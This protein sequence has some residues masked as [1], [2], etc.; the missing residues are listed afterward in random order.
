MISTFEAIGSI[1]NG[2]VVNN[3]VLAKSFATLTPQKI[4]DIAATNGLSEATLTLTLKTAGLTK[5]QRGEVYQQ[6]NAIKAKQA[7]ATAA[8]SQA[9]ATSGTTV[10]VKSL[11][12]AL[13]GL[14]TTVKSFAAAN[15]L[16]TALIAVGAAFGI[17][18]IAADKFGV[19]AKGAAEKFEKAKNSYV[20]TANE[21][22]SVNS[23]LETTRSRI[24]ELNKLAETGRLTPDQEAELDD[25]N[26]TN[27]ALERKLK[28]LED[29]AVYQQREAADAAAKSYQSTR[30]ESKTKT[31]FDDTSGVSYAVQMNGAEYIQDLVKASRD[32]TEQKEVLEARKGELAALLANGGLSPSQSLEAESELA[33]INN[34][35]AYIDST[36][37]EYQSELANVA[38]EQ[39]V[40]ADSLAKGTDA[41]KAQAESI[42]DAIDAYHLLG[43][44]EQEVLAHLRENAPDG[45][46]SVAKSMEPIIDEYLAAKDVYEK[47]F[48]NN[49]E[50]EK[51]S[52]RYNK[53]ILDLQDG[54]DKLEGNEAFQE[55]VDDAMELDFISGVTRDDMIK[56]IL[57]IVKL[58]NAA[59]DTSPSVGDLASH[60]ATLGNA[61]TNFGDLSEALAEFRDEGIVSIA[62]LADLQEAFGTTDGFEK[63]V[64]IVG[65]SNSTFAEAKAA[66][67]ELA[68]EWINN[69]FIC[70]DLT[71]NTKDM[72]IATLENIGVTNAAEV[73]EAELAARRVE[74]KIAAL[75]EKEA[76]W[77]VIEAL[78][79]EAITAAD[80]ITVI[81]RLTAEREAARVASIDFVTASSDTITALYNEALAAGNAAE[82]WAD[83]AAIIQTKNYISAHPELPEYQLNYFE[84]QLRDW[85]SNVQAKITNLG[86][87]IR[88]TPSITPTVKED[89]GGETDKIKEEFEALYA[90]KKHLL[91][92]ERISTKEFYDWLID[93]EEGYMHYFKENTDEWRKYEKEAF[94]LRKQL[95]EDYLDDIDDEIDALERQGDSETQ[96]IAKYKEKQTVIKDLMEAHVA[97]LKAI[98]AT[99]DAIANNEYLKELLSQWW[100]LQ[101]LI[102]DTTD[103]INDEL[104]DG[105]KTLLDMTI[106]II[107]KEGEDAVDALEEQKDL[108][109]EIVS[110]RREMLKMAEQERQYNDEVAEKT[111][112]LAKLE[113]RIAT[114]RLDDSRE[115]AVERA[116]LEEQKAELQKE[117][118]ELQNDHWLDSV[119]AALEK[120][121]EDWEN[122]QDSKI[123]EIEDMLDDEV[124]LR[125]KAIA[126]LDN[127]N[128]E[129]FDDLLSYAVNYCDMSTLEFEKM[130][131]AALAAAEKYGSYLN[132]ME[133][134]PGSDKETQ[135]S[136]IIDQMEKN[137]AAYAASTSKSEREYYDQQNLKLGAQ[138]A[139]VTGQNV[140]RDRNG[141]WWIDDE[142][143]FDYGL[144][145]GNSQSSVSKRN[146]EKVSDIVA[147]MKAYGKRWS[148][149]NTPEE[150]GKIHEVVAE[151]AKD[152][153]KYGVYVDYQAA[154]GRWII[155]KDNNDPTKVGKVLYDVYHQGGVV[156]IPTMKQNEH[157]SLL[158]RG[159]MI[160]T[161]T[162][163]N[164][165]DKLIEF[166]KK[167]SQIPSTVAGMF[168]SNNTAQTISVE[169]PLYITGDMS[170]TKILSVLKKHSRLV[171]NEVAKVVNVK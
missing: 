6:Y 77:D 164:A 7:A 27:E 60:L 24:E 123:D 138:L 87:D 32:L 125:A 168:N 31:G 76:T 163:Q 38:S 28:I 18:K 39:E 155:V 57:A 144:G 117:L 74:A 48:A 50:L 2:V 96:I 122:Q 100:E 51:P 141:Y 90:E 150:N 68:T 165:L 110:Q 73:V 78:Y 89:S 10:A 34:E 25:L 148:A 133:A 20:E 127:M 169:A 54:L 161:E 121:L 17:A 154:S 112:A 162:H 124:Q 67:D 91:D 5:A 14:W 136:S 46:A 82:V 79:D 157:L 1:S 108:Y 16:I 128:D 36:Y 166:S 47:A 23:E 147:D 83:Y 88:Y 95:S 97:Y 19:S 9:A 129:L 126:K 160:L 15:P 62:T 70:K 113:A 101:D 66:F 33:R 61:E 130:W 43:A 69:Q 8:G 56:L 120:E 71:E 81:K 109:S 107:K 29:L 63:F 93:T 86:A 42:Y 84:K 158:E 3:A 134:V 64:N 21:L 106:E 143:L 145:T 149:S 99:D 85:Q 137:R 114:L 119:D 171:A 167:V 159:E 115:A 72:T 142:Y 135:A 37:S 40:F 41:H 11:S 30:Y 104:A 4:A 94:D 80:D 153:Q 151:Y 49:D 116:A 65:D 131:D 22:Q 102:W 45:A 44:S 55:L 132:A 12:A 118:A 170:E 59:D 103:T 140:Y 58:G 26:K 92:T 146:S 105:M 156:G 75:D 53:A 139:E 52:A 35:V 98:G 111:A 152:L 13:T